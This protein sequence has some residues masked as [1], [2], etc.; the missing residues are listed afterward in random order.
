MFPVGETLIDK[1]TILLP[2]LI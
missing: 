2:S 1:T